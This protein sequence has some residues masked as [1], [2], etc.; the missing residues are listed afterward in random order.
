MMVNYGE[1]RILMEWINHDVVLLAPDLGMHMVSHG[2]LER[3]R[4]KCAF[5]VFS[6]IR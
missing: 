4:W 3:L 6:I 1:G 2:M 5:M